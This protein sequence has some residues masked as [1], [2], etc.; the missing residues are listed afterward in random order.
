M[1]AENAEE[2]LTL[3]ADAWFGAG[4]SA[5]A[6]SFRT[7]FETVAQLDTLGAFTTNETALLLC[8]AA[9]VTW[10]EE[11]VREHVVPAAQPP[12]YEK[13]DVEFEWLIQELLDMPNDARAMFLNFVTARRR[14][15]AGGLRSLPPLVGSSGSSGN[16][17]ASTAG[18]KITVDASSGAAPLMKGNTCNYRLHMPRG[19]ASRAELKHYLYRS[20][21][22]SSGMKD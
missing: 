15:P 16:G 14:L 2:Y 13:G 20:M 1:T 8:G 12:T 5:Q 18:A 7:G 9:A 10:D 3:I 22:W 17:G 19:Y 6:A 11:T 4:V 21:E